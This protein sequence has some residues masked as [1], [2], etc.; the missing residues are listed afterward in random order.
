MERQNETKKTK[1]KSKYKFMTENK[2]YPIHQI[3]NIVN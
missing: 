1:N 3:I 2:N